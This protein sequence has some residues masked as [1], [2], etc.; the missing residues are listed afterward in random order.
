MGKIAPIYQRL[1]SRAKPGFGISSMVDESNQCANGI[2]VRNIYIDR[3]VDG[4][5][6]KAS[7]AELAASETA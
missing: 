2:F 7:L 4:S 1:T 3:S 6:R 5:V